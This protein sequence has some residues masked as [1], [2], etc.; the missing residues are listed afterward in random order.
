MIDLMKSGNRSDR[1]LYKEWIFD[2]LKTELLGS[3][4][5]IMN[6]GDER[7]FKRALKEKK[8]EL[9][10]ELDLSIPYQISRAS[11]SARDLTQAAEIP[12]V[13]WFSRTFNPE[14]SL[15][16]Q[17]SLSGFTDSMG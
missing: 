6:T 17:W 16:V 10:T 5:L 7:S 3:K 4:H 11:W 14:L 2:T 12:D 15:A 8:R 1:K 9:S 13:I